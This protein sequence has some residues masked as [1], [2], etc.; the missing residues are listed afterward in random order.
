MA[1]A[2]KKSKKILK[3]SVRILILAVLLFFILVP[4]WWAVTISFNEKAIS[5]VPK[6]SWWPEYTSLKSY[7]YAFKTIKLVRLY[8]NTLM[9]TVINV[10]ISV[11]FAM[12][13]GYAFSK[14]R[15]VGKKFWYLFMM[16]VMMIPFESRMIPLY[17]QYNG[18][19]MIN[20]YWPLI[21]GNFAYV[22]GMIFATANIKALPDALRES[23]CLDGAGEWTIFLRIILPL[24]KP[25]ISALAILQTVNQWNSYLWPMVVLR[26]REMTVLTV[27]I[28]LFNAEEN[29]VYLGPRMAVA[30]LSA[31]PLV[32]VFLFLQKYIVESVA[33][34]GIKQ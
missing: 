29:S 25:I 12:C 1:R 20:T 18:W 32:I 13:C 30:V 22:F 7:D 10:V 5:S 16:A 31:V 6:F 14:G 26:N 3:R 2:E 15:F 9:I 27:G 24:S 21:L 11:F 19:G 33:M 23:A 17:L 28:S 8:A 4:L 34:T